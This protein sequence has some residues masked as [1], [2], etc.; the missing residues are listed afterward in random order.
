MLH[1]S[2]DWPGLLPSRAI[3]DKRE[4]LQI[5]QL[6]CLNMRHTYMNFTDKFEFFEL[7]T[8]QF[9]QQCRKHLVSSEKLNFAK[10]EVISMKYIQSRPK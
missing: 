7:V 8:R 10:T 9:C 1:F 4:I 5:I 2:L 6:F 3:S